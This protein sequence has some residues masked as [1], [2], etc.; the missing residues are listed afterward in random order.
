ML[1]LSYL[2]NS[3]GEVNEPDSKLIVAEGG[4]GGCKETDYCGRRGQVRR[5][6]LDLKLI[7][8]VSLVGF[9]NAGKSTFLKTVSKAAP[10]VAEYPCKCLLHFLLY[11][12]KRY[13]LF[14]ETL[15]QLQP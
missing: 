13:Q 15:L 3:V 1:I 12:D 11:F 10:K 9:P 6:H 2:F 8:D 4:L 5:I 7:S 14:F